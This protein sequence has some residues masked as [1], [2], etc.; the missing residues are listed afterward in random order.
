MPREMQLRYAD[1]DAGIMIPH[2]IGGG[3]GACDLWRARCVLH[4]KP[5]S[6]GPCGAPACCLSCEASTSLECSRHCNW[7]RSYRVRSVAT[8]GSVIGIDITEPMIAEAERLQKDRP[9]ANITFQI[10]DVHQLPFEDGIF[11][12]VTCRRAAH[13]FSNIQRALTEIWRVLRPGGII[14]ID[15]RSVPEDDFLDRCMNLLDTYHDESH[16]REYRPGEWRRMLEENGFH[17]ETLEPYIQHRPLTSLTRDVSDENVKRIHS[18]LDR[19]SG[20]QKEAF[21]LVEI[22]GELYLNHWYVLVSGSRQ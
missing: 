14:V 12:L 18:T 10:G 8:C 4:D 20:S 9:A 13:H 6:L 19:L 16:I 7:N 1:A 21:H 22:N 17:V 2:G 11:D 5:D 3:Q 15:D